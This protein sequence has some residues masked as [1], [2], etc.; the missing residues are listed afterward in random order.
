MARWLIIGTVLVV[1]GCAPVPDGGS[2][3]GLLPDFGVLSWKQWIAW[4]FRGPGIIISVILGLA[5]WRVNRA[6][7]RGKYSDPSVPIASPPSSLS[8]AAVSIL[9]NREV[10]GR[11]RLAIILE[12]CQRG[13]LKVVGVRERERHTSVGRYSY[14]FSPEEPAEHDWER[15]I[16]DRISNRDVFIQDLNKTL[17]AQDSNIGERLGEYLRWRGLFNDNP[18]RVWNDAPGM[19]LGRITLALA[20]MGTGVGLWLGLWVSQWWVNAIG[21]GII[22]IIYGLTVG[23]MRVGMIAPTSSGRHEIGQWVAFKEWLQRSSFNLTAAPPDSFLPYAIALDAAQPWLGDGVSAPEWFGVDTG[24]N[25]RRSNRDEAY[26]AFLSA[27]EWG[28]E[29]RSERAGELAIRR[30]DGSGPRVLE[31]RRTPAAAVGSPVTVQRATERSEAGLARNARLTTEPVPE[32][33]EAS[34]VRDEAPVYAP[35]QEQVFFDADRV[36]V[37]DYRLRFPYKTELENRVRFPIRTVEMFRIR[38]AVVEESGMPAEAGLN[39]L[40]EVIGGV[41][42]WPAFLGAMGILII[43]LLNILVLVLGHYELT[44]PGLPQGKTPVFIEALG[45]TFEAF[46]VRFSLVIGGFIVSLGGVAWIGDRIMNWRPVKKAK[47]RVGIDVV[48]RRGERERLY[49]G[50]YDELAEARRI[51]SAIDHAKVAIAARPSQR[52]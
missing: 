38:S 51:V 17:E 19:P 4:A 24:P 10:T 6:W 11:T 21:G 33:Q 36:F 43:L 46:P 26:R 22:G 14:R 28:L 23:P 52:V 2:A 50:E 7:F 27:P 31:P 49:F 37:S 8:A 15:S 20:L 45:D 34:E 5:L 12:M 25:A 35:I 29:G 44:E 47:Y 32:Q 39:K 42:K 41:I 1:V 30:A 40:L 16:A 3:A 9:E 18:V 13:T 48:D